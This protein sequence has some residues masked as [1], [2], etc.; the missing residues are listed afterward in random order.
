MN[1][2]PDLTSQWFT[3][4][5]PQRGP[6]VS[7]ALPVATR[8]WWASF[9]VLGVYIVLAYL[10]SEGSAPFDESVADILYTVW[11]LDALC[12]MIVTVVVAVMLG[13]ERRQLALDATSNASDES[14]LRHVHRVAARCW[15]ASL[16]LTAF[17]VLAVIA[18]S[19]PGPPYDDSFGEIVWFLPVVGGWCL[20]LFSI[21]VGALWGQARARPALEEKAAE[22]SELRASRGRLVDASDAARRK[23]ERNL[24]D[25][26]QPRLVA[27]LLNVSMARRAGQPTSVLLPA[28]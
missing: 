21:V 17:A 1:A 15:F 19:E 23:I 13:E 8:C 18:W 16:V 6:D 26:V 28:R 24:H 14:R 25:G 12:L 22:V 3:S 2:Q 20:L 7:R 5:V 11:L 10:W 4:K 9:A 27:L